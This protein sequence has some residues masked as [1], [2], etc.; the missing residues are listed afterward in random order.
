MGHDNGI[1]FGGGFMW[2]FWVVL[3]VV[4]VYI[5][6]AVVGDNKTVENNST[7]TQQIETPL[8]IL[9]KRLAAGEI[10]EDEFNR[11]RVKLED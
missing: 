9:Q 8:N 5:V 3:F 4:I 7:N 1:F 10:D 6:R 11:L 2:I